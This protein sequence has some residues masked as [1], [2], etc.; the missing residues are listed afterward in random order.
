MCYQV[1]FLLPLRLQKM[2]CYFWLCRKIL[3]AS[4]FPG[5]FTFDLFDLL[6]LVLGVHC[7]IGFVFGWA[8]SKNGYGFLAHVIL[9]SVVP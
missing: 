7:Y 2:S 6:I 9:N 1:D 4:Q 5:F 8:W 3:S